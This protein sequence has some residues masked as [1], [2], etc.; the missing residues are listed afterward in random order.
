M[1]AAV[2]D[3]IGIGQGEPRQLGTFGH[4][5]DRKREGGQ[6][7]TKAA[8]NVGLLRFVVAVFG[9]LPLITPVWVYAALMMACGAM[10]V[11]PLIAAAAATKPMVRPSLVTSRA[12]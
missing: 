8:D 11:P 3:Q 4:F 5:G 7:A 12:T 10:V 1:E 9:R 6:P 2:G